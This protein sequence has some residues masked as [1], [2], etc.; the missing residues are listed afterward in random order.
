MRELAWM[1]TQDIDDQDATDADTEDNLDN[2]LAEG[3]DSDCTHSKQSGGELSEWLMMQHYE[4][5]KDEHDYP[6]LWANIHKFW[7]ESVTGAKD[8]SSKSMVGLV[9]TCRDAF[10]QAVNVS[11]ILGMT[12]QPSRHK[13]ASK[14]QTDMV[15]L[16]D[17]LTTI[18]KY[19]ALDSAVEVPLPNFASMSHVSYD[20]NLTL[21]P[22]ESGWDHNHHI[23][24]LVLL[25]KLC[26]LLST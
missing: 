14:R 8:M 15:R 19:K 22:Q 21:Q 18:I 17:Y 3:S 16:M 10:M 26:K 25:H 11:F 20:C 2:G 24:P 13:L 1:A 12:K 5:H 23:L 6:Q 9:M 4:E 7:K